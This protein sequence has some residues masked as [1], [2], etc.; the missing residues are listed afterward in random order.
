MVNTPILFE[1]FARPQYA[2]QVFD[3]IKSAQPKK[4]YF[5]SNKGR[6]EKEGEVEC[7]EEIK[8][9]AKEVDWDCELHTYFREDYADIYTSLKGALDWVFENEVEAIILEDDCVPTSAFF[10]FCDQMIEKYRNEPKVW[11]ISGDNYIGYKPENADY[12]FSQYH[13]MFGW[14]SWRDRWNK[15]EWDTL[16]V[17]NF[18]NSKIAYDLFRTKKQAKSREKELWFF[19]KKVETTKCWDYAFGYVIDKNKGVTVHPNEHLV[20]C[21]GMWG[22]HNK[23]VRETMFHVKANPTFQNYKIEKEPNVIVPDKKF[24]YKF[25]KVFEHYKSFGNRIIGYLYRKFDFLFSK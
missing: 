6:T 4:L 13:F 20:T 22:T 7:N 17:E 14:A 12:F 3:A 24:D 18:I 11:C 15:I 2:R 25:F 21:V 5:Y 19:K 10:S 9:W 23:A 8:S 1:T 16:D